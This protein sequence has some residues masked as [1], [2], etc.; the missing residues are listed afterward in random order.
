[1]GE[2]VLELAGKELDVLCELGQ[3]GFGGLGGAEV[4]EDRLVDRKA[5]DD[6]GVR[7]GGGGLKLAQRGV[8]DAGHRRQTALLQPSPAIPF[9]I[10]P[11]FERQARLVVDHLVGQ[12]QVLL[13]ADALEDLRSL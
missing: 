5:I 6:L 3:G 13:F 8:G 11:R 9:L 1:M 2:I 12:L 10:R 7:R 4:G